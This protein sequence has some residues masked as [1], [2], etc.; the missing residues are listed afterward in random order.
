MQGSPEQREAID[1]TSFAITARVAM[2]LGR[3]SISNS[4]IAIT[5]LVKNAYDADA[6]NVRIIFWDLDTEHPILV[7][8][9]DGNGMNLQQ[10]KDSWMVIGTDYKQ[11]SPRS[12]QKKRVLTGEKGLGRLGL[13]RLCEMSQLQTFTEGN[14]SGIEVEIDWRKYENTSARLESI[15]HEVYSIS[16]NLLVVSPDCS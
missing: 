3:E 12:N 15:E 13:D 7:I 1:S 6:E 8:D 14:P 5:E 11:F 16:K 10:L 9:D 4:L 2:Q